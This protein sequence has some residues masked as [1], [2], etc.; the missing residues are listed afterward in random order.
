[1]LCKHH[2][3]TALRLLNKQSQLPILMIL[4]LSHNQI[5]KI[6]KKQIPLASSTNA[7]SNTNSTEQSSP[8]HLPTSTPNAPLT[9]ASSTN[10][11]STSTTKSPSTAAS[12]TI[13]QILIVAA[14]TDATI[15]AVSKYFRIYKKL[16]NSL[17]M[18][19]VLTMITPQLLSALKASRDKM[20]TPP[21]SL[22][23][24]FLTATTSDSTI[25]KLNVAQCIFALTKYCESRE[26]IPNDRYLRNLTRH[27]LLIQVTKARDALSGKPNNVQQQASSNT[28]NTATPTS[29]TKKS[30][31][32]IT[33]RDL[34]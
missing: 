29:N 31:S 27:Q 21:S 9:N 4:L 20:A 23:Q 8:N 6:A 16:N 2:H 5:H 30:K 10:T 15:D 26:I 32:K 12:D 14:T 25:E 17:T 28:T 33:K 1:M 13:Q 19:K 34:A 22:T 24:F 3:K 18:D 7:S 11:P